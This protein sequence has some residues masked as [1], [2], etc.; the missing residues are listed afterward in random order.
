MRQ[1][2]NVSGGDVQG[3]GVISQDRRGTGP[4]DTG[5]EGTTMAAEREFEFDLVFALP[6]DAVDE[7]AILDAPYEAGCG[8]AAIGLGAPGLVGVGITRSGKDP[9]AV[10]AAAA[11]QLLKECPEGTMLREVR[12][13]L[14]KLG[15][16]GRST[17][18]YTAGPAK[19]ANAAA[20]GGK[21]LQGFGDAALF[22]R[23]RRQDSG[24]FSRCSGVVRGRPGRSTGKRQNR[25]KRIRA[26]LKLFL[27]PV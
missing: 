4:F 8:D 24:G 13:D 2:S 19:E 20:L 15:G 25:P 21:P 10:I 18:G 16:C 23:G 12:P 17:E 27:R 26:R 5:S 14:V 22:G 11:K 9:E 6:E 3:S 7:G 1:E